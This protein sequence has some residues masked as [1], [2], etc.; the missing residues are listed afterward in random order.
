MMLY[1]EIVLRNSFEFL[2][3]AKRCSG[4]TKQRVSKDMPVINPMERYK[5]GQR[6]PGGGVAMLYM[7]IRDGLVVRMFKKTTEDVKRYV[8]ICDNK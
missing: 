7:M 6:N 2:L 3:C 8:H 5:Q 4:C 1:E